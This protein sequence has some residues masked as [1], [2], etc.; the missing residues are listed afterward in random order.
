MTVVVIGLFQPPV[1]FQALTG[2]GTNSCCNRGLYFYLLI[3]VWCTCYKLSSIQN[4][5]DLHS[6]M[7]ASIKPLLSLSCY[8]NDHNELRSGKR[9][10][11]N[12]WGLSL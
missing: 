8:G 2:C 5:Q 1:L 4:Q 9:R 7:Y 12:R 6:R 10:S 3:T 11:A